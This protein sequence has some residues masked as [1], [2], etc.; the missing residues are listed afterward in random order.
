M[1]YKKHESTK[2]QL[3]RSIRHIQI[4]LKQIKASNPMVNLFHTVDLCLAH[5]KAKLLHMYVHR[6]Y[7]F[8]CNHKGLA[9]SPLHYKVSHVHED[10][11]AGWT[12][13]LN[14]QTNRH[15]DCKVTI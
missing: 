2:K 5:S 11:Q 15:E 4:G 9:R 14:R 12:H 3:G 7:I 6:I 10:M 1:K 8:I 13:A